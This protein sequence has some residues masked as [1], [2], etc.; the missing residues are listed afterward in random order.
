MFCNFA[1]N[2]CWTSDRHFV[3]SLVITCDILYYNLNLSAPYGE[4]SRTK[5]RTRGKL[6]ALVTANGA[7]TAEPQLPARQPTQTT[8]W[9]LQIARRD[10]TWIGPAASTE[11]DD[12]L[13]QQ[14]IQSGLI[15]I[16][17]LNYLQATVHFG[18]GDRHTGNI[19]VAPTSIILYCTYLHRTVYV[20]VVFKVMY[21]CTNVLSI[22]VNLQATHS[23]GI[24]HS[25]SYIPVVYRYSYSVLYCVQNYNLRVHIRTTHDVFYRNF[26]NYV[27]TTTYM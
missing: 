18:Y 24:L 16:R 23:T 2:K 12:R 8:L 13:V 14:V 5:W 15:M 25:N 3:S 27:R 21:Y 7:A 26:T 20:H 9:Q 19:Q 10:T 1:T 17:R 6:L 11:H 4:H 22:S